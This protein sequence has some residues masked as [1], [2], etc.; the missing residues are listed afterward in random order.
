MKL[1]KAI[2][3]LLFLL[4]LQLIHSIRIRLTYSRS[5]STGNLKFFGSMI[6]VADASYELK[7]LDKKL[8]DI[9]K[10][11]K[12]SSCDCHA[13]VVAHK[14]EN[15]MVVSIRGTYSWSNVLADLKIWRVTY[16]PCPKDCGVHNGFFH[17]Y[18]NIKAKLDETVDAVSRNSA[19]GLKIVVTGHSLGGAV[20]TLY[21]AHI[22]QRW[23]KY[24]GNV[25]LVTYG[26]PRV[27]NKAF[28]KYINNLLETKNIY[29]IKY[30]N[31]P[32]TYIPLTSWGYQHVG[33]VVY[34]FSLQ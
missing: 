6:K 21:A 26:S 28:V 32:V 16:P 10:L 7:Y 20:A 5:V 13:L 19:P 15:I 14:R 31:N 24:K 9:V 29:R 4:Y 17:Y 27:G 33:D 12:I 8:W 30:K 11:V 3:K 2:L 1:I 22:L 23:H 34:S 25:Q 18:N